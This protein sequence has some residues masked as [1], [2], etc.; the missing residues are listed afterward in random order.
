M[1][2]RARRDEGLGEQAAPLLLLINFL[3]FLMK[4]DK[5][6]IKIQEEGTFLGTHS[7][8]LQSR[9]LAGSRVSAAAGF[10]SWLSPRLAAQSCAKRG[11]VHLARK[12]QDTVE[13]Q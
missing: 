6:Y 3:G 13:N 11:R 2:T 1:G 10:Y 12:P 5:R 9:L 8:W 4:R 7:C